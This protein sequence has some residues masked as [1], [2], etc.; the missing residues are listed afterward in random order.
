MADTDHHDV[1]EQSAARAPA[2]AAA[3]T[4]GG[5]L[6]QRHLFDVPGDVS[7]FNTASLSPVLRSVQDAGR[8][9]VDRRSRPWT[10]SP[11]DWF[12][13]VE[14]LRTRVAALLAAPAESMALVPAT[15]YG[16][17]TAARNLPLEP[18]QRVLVLDEEYPSNY[19][20]WRRATEQAGAEL[21]VVTQEPE[22]TWA[23]AVLERLDERVA[24]VA[25]PN[26]HWTDG[27]LVDLQALA[28]YVHAS[29]AAW[30][31]DASQSWGV[32]PLDLGVLRPDFVVAVGYK[33]L[34]GPF[35]LGYLYVDQRHHN[36]VPLE[37]NW[38]SRSGAE[39]FAA[40]VD[41]TDAYLPGAQRFDVGQRTNFGLVPM[42]TAAVEQLASWG[43]ADVGQA[44]GALNGRLAERLAD[45][46]VQLLSQAQRGPH[47]LGVRMP[48]NVDATDV[49]TELTRR[50]IST[51]MRGSSLRLSP[52]LHVTDQDLDRLA[53][54]LRDA[55]TK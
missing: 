35:S 39:D 37:E 51:S 43:V 7:Y 14:T 40:L 16:L 20:T 13:E 10:V 12:T 24:V 4:A 42:A 2:A 46:P 47:V 5:L 38:I 9:G 3:R 18:G 28:P 11:Q 49:L 27:A 34:L 25:V 52:H 36:G 53:Q 23:Q 33:W 45:L 15:S 31:I 32:M 50:G 55:L 19:Y 17:A 6:D 1:S 30:V 8:E 29:G 48:Q 21:V 26:V 22:Q 54:A 44:L 41:Y